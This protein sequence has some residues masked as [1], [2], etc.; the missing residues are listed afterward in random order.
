MPVLLPVASEKERFT[1]QLGVWSLTFYLYFNVRSQLW[2]FDMTDALT[3]E[4]LLLGHPVVLGQDFL[5]PY[6]MGIGAIFAYDTTGQHAEAT[7]DDL[8][9]RVLLPYLTPD[10]MAAP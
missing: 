2:M 5:E 7:P 6:I 9:D 1:T 10:E 3:G 4:P 8:G